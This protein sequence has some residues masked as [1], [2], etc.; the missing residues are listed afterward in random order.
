[1]KNSILFPFS[2]VAGAALCLSQ[3]QVFGQDSGTDAASPPDP[4]VD[5]A[6]DE[7]VMDADPTVETDQVVEEAETEIDATPE[8]AAPSMT[9]AGKPV[10]VEP[11]PAIDKEIAVVKKSGFFEHYIKDR[12]SIGTRV[13][14][15]S[16][17]DTE[18]GEEFDGSFLGSIN[19][20]EED[21]D[22]APV[23][24]YVEYAIT[25][26]FGIG[27]S[28]D[29]FKVKTLDSGGGDGTFEL[30]GPI[31]YG[32]GRFENGSAFTPF[33]EIG[34]AFYSNSFNARDEWT[35]S[36]GSSTVRNRFEPDDATGFVIAGGL[37][38]EIVENLSAN[39]Y[40]RYTSVDFDVDYYFTPNSTTTPYRKGTFPGDHFSYGIGLKYTF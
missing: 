38:Y 20:T 12:L 36:D 24:I 28:Y 32:F 6:I 31:I 11:S 15:Y 30:D 23:Y 9:P 13:L 25:P 14:W 7:Q 17:T 4:L 1:M 40:L 37:D 39:I 5:A 8:T 16:L 21:Q 29:Q 34:M 33:A 10:T 2:I 35:F 19:R 22:L 27:I 26:Y 18:Q 3:P